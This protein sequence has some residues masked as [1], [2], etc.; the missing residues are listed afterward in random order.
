MCELQTTNHQEKKCLVIIELVADEF[1]LSVVNKHQCN[2]L[3]CVVPEII[4]LL[5]LVMI[6]QRIV[7]TGLV[8][9]NCIR[10]HQLLFFKLTQLAQL[11]QKN[12]GKP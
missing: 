4:Y 8:T 7:K 6:I 5:L 12:L 9:E 10:N 3:L 1:L 2:C 11:S